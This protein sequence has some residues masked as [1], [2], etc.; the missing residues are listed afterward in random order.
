M[1]RFFAA[2]LAVCLTGVLLPGPARAAG[3]GTSASSAILVDA[4]S[5]RVLYEQNAHERRLIASITKLMTALVAVESPAGLDVPVEI[6]PEWT[7]AEGSSMYLRAGERLTLRELL[8]GL[9][10][11]SGNDAAVAVACVCAGDVE[12]FVAWMNDKAEEL[13]MADTHFANPN[14][15]NDEDHYS[16]A[17]DMARLARVVLENEVLAGIVGTKSITIAG[18]SLTNHNKLL[19]RY[20]GCVGMKTGYTD[21]AGR[22]LV[23]CAR[24]E[25]QTLIAVTLNDPDDWRDHAALFDYGFSQYPAHML[26]LAGREFRTVPLDGSLSRFVPVRTYQDV[27]YPLTGQERVTARITLPERVQAPVT[28]GDIAGAIT[29]YLEGEPIGESYLVYARS[30]ASDADSGRGLAGRL[31]DLLRRQEGLASLLLPPD[32]ECSDR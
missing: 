6:R 31:L 25:G 21:K 17:A 19:W 5:G 8:Y 27:Y 26:A 7:G 14:G 30:A 20:E 23:S 12:T 28:E 11:A 24:R 1:K 29:F 2:L 13:G 22:T 32:R 3:P 15:L 9:L 16:T 4:G 18:R 10:L